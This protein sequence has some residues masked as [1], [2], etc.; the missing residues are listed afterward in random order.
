[1]QSGVGPRFVNLGDAPR[2]PSGPY[3]DVYRNLINP[4][5]PAGTV[6]TPGQ[7]LLWSVQVLVMSVV[8]FG[9]APAVY[10]M[11][12]H[13]RRSR[14]T[15]V[16]REGT[17][18]EG[19]IRTVDQGDHYATFRYEYEVGDSIYSAFLKYPKEM[20]RFWGPGDIVP[21]LYDRRDP[22]RSCF[23]YR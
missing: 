21:V 17:F 20:A 22:T 16:F 14:F 13:D 8:S 4:L 12:W 6:R 23:L 10:L 15:D 18:S 19:V 5:F 2:D 9:I 1:M 11:R 7:K 3:A